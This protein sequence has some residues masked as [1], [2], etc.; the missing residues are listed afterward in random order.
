MIFRKRRKSAGSAGCDV[1]MF[2]VRR[3]LRAV[4]LL[5]RERAGKQNK[6]DKAFHHL[7]LNSDSSLQAAHNRISRETYSPERYPLMTRR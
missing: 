1:A 3:K 5:P 4:L 7:D 2:D 6:N